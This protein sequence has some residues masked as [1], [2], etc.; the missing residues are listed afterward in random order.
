MA[1]QLRK[2]FTTP[3]TF[4]LPYLVELLENHAKMHV[5]SLLEQGTLL[6]I[7]LQGVQGRRSWKPGRTA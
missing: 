3:A 1:G 4:F 7:S 6:A 5:E 2:L